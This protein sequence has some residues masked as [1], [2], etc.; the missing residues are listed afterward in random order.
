MTFRDLDTTNLQQIFH[1]SSLAFIAPYTHPT[2]LGS[3]ILAGD[4]D[5]NTTLTLCAQQCRRQTLCRPVA[6][7]PVSLIGKACK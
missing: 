2:S 6:D 5:S 4:T 7:P 1:E 3:Y